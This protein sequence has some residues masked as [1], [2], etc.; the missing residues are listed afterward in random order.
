MHQISFHYF[1]GR[2]GGWLENWRVMLI[3]AFNLIEVEVEVEAELGKNKMIDCF[4]V[5]AQIL[6]IK[7]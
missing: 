4:N 2:M 7:N 5:K 3:S 6:Q 1:F